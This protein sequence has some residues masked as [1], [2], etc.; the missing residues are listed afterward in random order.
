MF[1]M[2]LMGFIL[3]RKMKLTLWFTAHVVMVWEWTC[4]GGMYTL[5]CIIFV[6][7]YIEHG[8]RGSVIYLQINLIFTRAV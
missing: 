5:V 7:D 3:E 8:I 1:C 4:L 6:K 2:G